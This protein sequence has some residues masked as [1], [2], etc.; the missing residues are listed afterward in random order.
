MTPLLERMEQRRKFT[1]DSIENMDTAARKDID[2]NVMT[3]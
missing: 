1:L 3:A 2:R